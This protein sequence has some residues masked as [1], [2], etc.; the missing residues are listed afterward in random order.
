MR[1]PQEGAVVPGVNVSKR[2]AGIVVAVICSLGLLLSCLYQ[3]LVDVAPKQAPSAIQLSAAP[4]WRDPVL[5]AV[6][7][8]TINPGFASQEMN[9]PAYVG[10]QLLVRVI[11]G[12]NDH[13]LSGIF[14]QS[15]ISSYRLISSSAH[16]VLLT[17]K[18]EADIKQVAAQLKQIKGVLSAE[19]DYYY[20]ADAVTPDDP[21]YPNL[22]GLDSSNDIDINAP[23]MWQQTTGSSNVVVAVLDSGIDYTHPDLAAN[24]WRNPGEIPG[25]GID[26]DGDGYI[27]DIYGIDVINHDSDPMDDNYHGTH[28]A[29]TIAA[30]GNNGI[31]VV[32][33]AWNAKL[34]A[35]KFMNANGQGSSSSAIECL[36]YLHTLKVNKGIN[37]VVSNNSWGGATYSDALLAEI[38]KQRDDGIMFIAS[39]GNNGTN[40]DTAPHYPASYSVDNL[41]AVAAV[42]NNGLLASF[43]NYSATSVQVAAPGVGIYSTLPGGT[44]GSYSGTSMA[45]PHITGMLALYA[46]NEPTAGWRTLKQH[47]LDNG[48]TLDSLSGKVLTGKL[49]KLSTL[50]DSDGDGVP[51]TRDNCPAIY[52]PDQADMDHDGIGNACDDDVDGD[53]IPNDLDSDDDN[54]GVA[55]NQDAFPLDPT[56]WRDTDG[57]GIG[58]NADSDDDNDGI[59]D[60]LDPQPLIPAVHLDQMF[61]NSGMQHQALGSDAHAMAAIEQGSGKVV[62]AGYA[63]NPAGKFTLVRYNSDGSID[64]SFGSAGI[65]SLV[66]GEARAMQ[67][68]ADGKLVVAGGFGSNFTVAR[69]N[70]NGALDSSFGI[71]GVASTNFGS[72][73]QYVRALTLQDDGGIVVAGYLY[74]NNGT[75]S[76]GDDIAVA[77]FT[78]KGILDSTF[79]TAGKLLIPV[80]SGDDVAL[81]I[82]SL[83]GNN[84]ALGGYTHNG[85]HDDALVIYLDNHGAINNAFAGNGIVRVTSGINARISSMALQADGKIIAGGF[86]AG[87]ATLWR[88]LPN[89][90]LDGGFGQSG[91]STV[92]VTGYSSRIKSV[93][94]QQDGKVVA[95]GEILNGSEQ[96]LLLAR[97][98]IDGTLDTTFNRG[99]V[100]RAISA[101]EDDLGE[102]VP[103]STGRLLVAA[104]SCLVFSGYCHK[105]DFLTLR[106]LTDF[107]SDGDGVTDNAD[108]FPNDA[109]RWLPPIDT[110]GDGIDNSIDNCPLVS[111][112]DQIDSDGDGIG[113]ACDTTPHG[114]QD[115][116]GIDNN[117]DNCRD[118]YNPDQHDRD[119]NGLGDACDPAAQLAG[120]GNQPGGQF[121]SAI[122]MA[123]MDAD[124][125]A[126][127]I[128]GIAHATIVDSHSLLGASIKHAGQMR[129]ISG[130]DAHIIHVFN[131]ATAS[132][133]FAS[134]IA[135]LPDL[136]RDGIPELLVGSPGLDHQRGC[137]SIYDGKSGALYRQIA[138]GNLSGDRFGSS[139]AAA[140]VNADG[141]LDWIIGSPEAQDRVG[142][143]V[144]TVS[145]INGLDN[146]LLQLLYGSQ[147]G[148]GFGSALAF[149][150]SDGK[151]W[152]GSPGYNRVEL[153][154]VRKVYPDTGRVQV[155]PSF[156]SPRVLFEVPGEQ[157]TGRFGSAIA[158]LPSGK[159]V[160]SAPLADAWYR[161]AGRLAVYDA[162]GNK[163]PGAVSGVT[164]N[165]HLGG[166][167]GVADLNH[168]GLAGLVVGASG[169]NG[170]LGG[171]GLAIPGLYGRIE[172]ITNLLS[173]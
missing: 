72:G 93:F 145:F 171:A 17:L 105:M 150:T 34:L 78:P 3:P 100:T 173:P 158:V 15:E 124:G 76:N 117:I 127:F 151:I 104:S 22:W 106:Y 45:T 23:E 133:H 63:Y 154:P 92:I 46:A 161:Q 116:D 75:G 2:R 65:S 134:A 111:N 77:R 71:N 138:C 68:Q 36:E 29:G 112:P 33:V 30:R 19:P 20:Q 135:V 148:E 84:L 7:P 28:V 82:L 108:Y 58:D 95:A 136:N 91:T 115:F 39:A 125:V 11:A 96:H 83:P 102:I 48:R 132:E 50:T 162:S 16:I 26:D 1:E 14:S 166:A 141:V 167:L 25:N 142:K 168:D 66:I 147:P 143:R 172:V 9:A 24:M 54:D 61:N 49:A 32:G 123:D 140:D 13:A 21:S 149:S 4:A 57:D 101:T 38:Q 90:N 69:Y 80:G 159:T 130:K 70:I 42:D 164:V 6:T 165:D 157:V 60:N 109:T 121:G 12:L 122:A 67:Q 114:D 144:G 18:A 35:C 87:N 53:G 103:L 56:E 119:G 137:V 107:D 99:V 118:T 73:Y 59:P 5:Q 27:D 64:N 110:D 152:V 98:L 37:I 31:G 163:L 129:I 44:Y 55:D 156:S 139:L 41:I 86:Y 51:D 169:Y 40:N 85:N 97:L 131:G 62:I 155:F 8:V 79:A 153:L 47:L 146:Q 160:I 74:S 128:V 113:D 170:K 52:N 120:Y 10:H 126:D 89:G 81:S 88:L 43:S 94:Q